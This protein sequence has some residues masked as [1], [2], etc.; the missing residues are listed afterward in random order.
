MT[1]VLQ[2]HLPQMP[3][4][5]PAT[6]R[7]PGIQPVAPGDWLRLDE[8]FAGQMAERDR[9]IRD[10]PQVVHALLPEA[11][12]PARELLD[13]VLTELPTLGGYELAEGTVRRPDGVA[14][15]LNR[16]APLLTLGRLVQEDFAI[17]T[18][19]GRE[20]ALTGAILCFPAS[21][22][23]AEKIGR[24]LTGIHAPVQVYDAQVA[25]RVQRLFDAIRPEQPL[26]RA[27]A[28][29]YQDPALHQPRRENERRPKPAERN[30]LRSERQCLVRLPQTGAVVF[31]IHT[32]VVHVDDVPPEALAAF[33]AL[34]P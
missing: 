2:R 30:Y 20:H 13:R 29:L 5:Q 7:L 25:A 8:A 16:D 15:A 9:L 33:R 11:E 24:R 31:S 17:H 4:M 19:E 12:A 3:W 23:L 18:P 26:W 10:C 27:N 32:T 34:H 6:A 14:V 21:W 1:P 28:L 22:T